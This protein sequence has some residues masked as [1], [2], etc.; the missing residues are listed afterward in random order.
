ML[1]AIV[2]REQD[3][4]AKVSGGVFVIDP[5]NLSDGVV[6]AIDSATTLVK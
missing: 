5:Q 1:Q 2:N 3:G 4:M 6:I